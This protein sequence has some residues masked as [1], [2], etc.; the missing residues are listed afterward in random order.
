[1]NMKGKPQIFLSHVQNDSE[2][3]NEIYF[4]LQ[5]QGYKPWMASRDLKPG[6]IWKSRVEFEIIN[7]DLILIFLSENSVNTSGYFRD[8]TRLAQQKA[9][10][11]K[12]DKQAFI[13][14]V[15]LD[16]SSV[17]SDIGQYQWIDLH[18]EDGRR[19]LLDTIDQVFIPKLSPPEPPKE[20]LKAYMNGDCIPFVGSGLSIRAGLPSL[21]NIVQNFLEI[22]TNENF[23]TRRRYNNL[24]RDIESGDIEFV[25]EN[26]LSS[27]NPEYENLLILKMKEAYLNID[28]TNLK[29]YELIYQIGSSGILTTNY[30]DL[31]ERSIPDKFSIYTSSDADEL[32]E[33]FSRGKRFL[34]K[35]HGSLLKPETIIVTSHQFE[36][37]VVNNRIFDEF[38]ANLVLSRT[39]LFIGLTMDDIMAFFSSF[40]SRSDYSRHYALVA[41][42]G[43]AWEA[44]SATLMLRYNVEVIPYQRNEQ[45]QVASFLETLKLQRISK[46]PDSYTKAV[47]VEPAKLAGIELVNIGPFNELDLELD[48][49]WNVLLGDNGVG[50]T[51]ILKAIAFGL[52]GKNA[53]QFANQLLK[54]GTNNGK[55]ILKTS[56]GKSYLTEIFRTSSGFDVNTKPEYPLEN[57]G[58]LALGFPPIRTF[59]WKRPSGPELF[60]DKTRPTYSD[61]LPLVSGNPDPRI[62]DIKQWILNLDYRSKDERLREQNQLVYSN[63]LTEYS[64]ILDEITDNVTITLTK[65]DLEKNQISVITDDGVVPIEFVSQGTASLIGWVGILVRRLYEVYS[66]E[67]NPTDRFAIVLIDEIDAHMHPKW[68]QSI[69]S[70]LCKL[71][72]KVQFIAT[73]HSPLIVG[74]MPLYQVH[75]FYRN[76]ENRSIINYEKLNKSLIG[77]RADQV[78]TS[79]AF[80]LKST[81]DQNTQKKINAYTKLFIRDDLTENEKKQLEELSTNLKM[82][83]PSSAEREEAREVYEMMHDILME[84]LKEKSPAERKKLLDE[85]QAQLLE[86]TSGSRRLK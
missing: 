62:D 21:T 83:I 52:C 81:R 60:D 43:T 79:S 65:V 64:R 13:I 26:I 49:H 50:K 59:S 54:H 61:L 63:L 27:L 10:R 6:E 19:K 34:L 51:S 42:S 2:I 78:L 29:E 17:P 75:K 82:R 15:R 7:S 9:E 38:L 76:E 24:V 35:L 20:L 14:P 55:I 44:Q 74:E 36:E 70:H 4:A 28:I 39:L 56:E 57:E 5:D 84:R 71:F 18:S 33:T 72:P 11:M 45:H 23:I 30:D 40:R 68:Q 86:S 3:V 1:M 37:E 73:S 77:W 31:L 46:I 67:Q 80:G 12:K 22:L 48:T 25:L 16:D 53:Q 8:E 58:W 85:I 32:F 47:I 41:V 66:D 69:I